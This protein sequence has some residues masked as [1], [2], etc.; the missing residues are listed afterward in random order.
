MGERGSAELRHLHGIKMPRTRNSCDGSVENAGSGTLPTPRHR[1]QTPCYLPPNRHARLTACS[2]RGGK[3]PVEWPEAHDW[4]RAASVP[5]L[6]LEPVPPRT[7]IELGVDETP[8]VNTAK[9]AHSS[10]LGL[11]AAQ[12]GWREDRSADF[13]DRQLP[14]AHVLWVVS[15]EELNNILSSPMRR[16]NTRVSRIPGMHELCRKARF[17]RLLRTSGDG[18]PAVE[19]SIRTWVLPDERPPPAAFNRGPLIVKPDDGS[20]GTGI[21]IATTPVELELIAAKM[22]RRGNAIA[23]AQ[24]Y[25][26]RPL[27]V[28]GYKFD[29]RL[30]VLV[31]SLRPLRVFLCNEGLARVCSEPYLE[32]TDS[33]TREERLRR[34]RLT[35]HLTN[36]GVSKHNDAHFDDCDD[37]KDGSRG[38]KRTLSATLAYM[39]ARGDISTDVWGDIC[40]LVRKTTLELGRA[41]RDER[42]EPELRL[43]SLWDNS[44][45]KSIGGWPAR[46]S[47][48]NPHK[49]GDREKRDCFQL[50]GVDIILDEQGTPHVLEANCGPS[51]N[52]D[53]VD[54][55]G[56]AA[57]PRQRSKIP[58]PPMHGDDANQTSAGETESFAGFPC[59][60]LNSR[61]RGH[62]TKVCRCSAIVK[63]HIHRPSKV[64]LVVKGQALRGLCEIVTRDIRAR[65]NG[66]HGDG[67][68]E[69]RPCIDRSNASR[70][71]A[72]LTAR[73]KANTD[74]WSTAAQCNPAPAV[75]NARSQRGQGQE[76]EQEQGQV[77]RSVDNLSRTAVSAA[78]LV[79]GTS[80][81]VIWAGD[82]DEVKECAALPDAPRSMQ[83]Q[84]QQSEQQSAQ[85][86]GPERQQQQQEE[87]QEQ[88]QEEK[89]EEEGAVEVVEAAVGVNGQQPLV[90]PPRT[91]PPVPDSDADEAAGPREVTTENAAPPSWAAGA[92]ECGK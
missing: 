71:G 47:A 65:S 53:K 9:T 55:V 50:L 62:G 22:A 33:A 59:D 14:R 5:V 2:H 20:Q 68:G 81:S 11:V 36:Y 29:L 76:Q 73:S 84:G 56:A 1:G 31:L 45:P 32:P 34:N 83:Q 74:I 4:R 67:S 25:V 16:E 13:F 51:F 52:F 86:Q 44:P 79:E 30:Y 82:E 24:E 19:P 64:D 6:A 63:P 49:L 10:M 88:E 75:D 43:A 48:W 42:T 70:S 23:V 12:L 28:D 61:L 80:Y 87:E 58:C 38:T 21:S 18:T 41:C 78:Q 66:G 3:L 35:R 54:V 40:G 37:P 91:P 69:S 92:E 39:Q 27:L 8:T 7:P 89:V 85:E 90:L 77:A 15:Q 60:L 46:G 57:T 72:G 26:D 17:A